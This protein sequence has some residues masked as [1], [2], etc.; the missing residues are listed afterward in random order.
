M[1]VGSLFL[2]CFYLFIYL[3][4]EMVKVQQ[5]PSLARHVR[6]STSNGMRRSSL[7]SCFRVS[8]FSLFNLCFP[9]QIRPPTLPTSFDFFPFLPGIAVS[10]EMEEV[11]YFYEID[12]SRLPPDSPPQ[13]RPCRVVM[14]RNLETIG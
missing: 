2:F 3:Q 7:P 8:R 1:G 5:S 4:E 11:G 12:H 13:L 9:S 10:E 14:V 6:H